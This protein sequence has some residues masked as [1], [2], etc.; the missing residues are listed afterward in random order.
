M[1]LRAPFAR[2]GL[3]DS[4]SGFSGCGHDETTHSF[5]VMTPL[6]Q[7]VS[8]HPTFKA[9]AG[10]IEEIHSLLE[11]FVAN[12]QS[13]PLCLFYDFTENGDLIF[14]REGY[15]GA[16]GVLAHLENVGELLGKML[17]MA[18]L[19]RL[20]LHGPAAELDQLR[21]PLAH[22]NADFFVLRCGI[23]H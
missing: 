5:A 16:A 13:E 11:E 12:T 6:T 18:D 4:I 21:G 22:L 2:R 14:C 17:T 8:I 1:S 19:I 7:Y 9:H 23:G 20:E 15:L 10:R 3:F